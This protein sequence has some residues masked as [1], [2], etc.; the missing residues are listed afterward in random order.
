MNHFLSEKMIIEICVGWRKSVMFLEYISLLFVYYAAILPVW[1]VKP[2]PA[3]FLYYHSDQRDVNRAFLFAAF[4][5]LLLIFDDISGWFLLFGIYSFIV[6]HMHFIDY[7]KNDD[8][9]HDLLRFLY[10][11]SMLLLLLFPWLSFMV[12]PI[13]IYSMILSTLFCYCLVTSNKW[14]AFGLCCFI[15]SDIMIL[16]DMVFTPSGY[17]IWVYY[18]SLYIIYKAIAKPIIMV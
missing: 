3:L 8:I 17:A 10:G 11:C 4:G 9:S 1:F 5:D 18:T 7:M 2:L 16:F 15:A 14:L 13:V 12:I 6:A